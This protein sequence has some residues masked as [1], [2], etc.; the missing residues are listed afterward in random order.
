LGLDR[1]TVRRYFKVAA[2]ASVQ[3]TGGAVSDDQVS[4]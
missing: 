1:T 3:A 2:T 4:C